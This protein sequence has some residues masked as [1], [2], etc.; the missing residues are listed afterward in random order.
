[1]NLASETID[2]ARN[3][4][5]DI[6]SLDEV[7]DFVSSFAVD[8]VTVV[9]FASKHAGYV[10]CACPACSFANQWWLSCGS[11]AVH[12]LVSCW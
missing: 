7:G 11:V 2:F 5:S 9:Q 6:V 10:G 8:T 1:M 12:F 4:L 3:S